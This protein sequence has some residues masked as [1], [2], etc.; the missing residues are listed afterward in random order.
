ME[1]SEKEPDLIAQ[2]EAFFSTF[3]RQVWTVVGISLS[4]IVLL[5]LIWYVAQVLLLVFAGILLA[6]LLRGLTRIVKHFTHVP[7]LAALAIVIVGILCFLGATGWLLAPGIGNQMGELGQALTDAIDE[8]EAFLSERAWGVWI[9]ERSPEVE[10]VMDDGDMIEPFLGIFSTALG[11][12]ANTLFIL[13]LGIY[14]AVNPGLYRRGIVLLFPKNKRR[15]ANEVVQT[16]GDQLWTWLV[17]QFITMT[18]IGLL[19]WVALIIIG[20][21]LAGALGF[22]AGLFEFVPIIGPWAA[23]VPGVM[24]AMSVSP[25]T[26]LWA[27][28]AYLLVQQI[29]SN[30]VSPLVARWMV[31]LPPAL[32]LAATIF[33]A[34]LFG[35]PGLL[36]ATPLALCVMILVRMVYV[37]DVLKD[38]IDP[39]P[40]TLE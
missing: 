21:P 35:L 37:E 11:A 27:I 10:A 23:A 6:V 7:D 32:T 1:T 25:T 13:I 15:R 16:L 36:L 4:V 2:D 14:L 3:S 24:I 19:T 5:L 12:I 29:E 8:V 40:E 9:L 17:G 38:R 39:V 22:I 33:A 34:V 31:A 20:V 26:A 30:L 18:I 28:V